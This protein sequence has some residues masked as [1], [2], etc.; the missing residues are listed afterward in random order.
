[1]CIHREG[2]FSS[3]VLPGSL[4]QKAMLVLLH[5]EDRVRLW[6]PSSFVEESTLA[7]AAL[8]HTGNIGQVQ[9]HRREIPNQSASKT[10]LGLLLHPEAAILLDIRAA[11]GL[12]SSVEVMLVLLVE[13]PWP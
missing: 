7:S 9:Q 5:D 12:L 2:S 8:P 4:L 11:S 1:M 10:L 3:V 6:A 13:V